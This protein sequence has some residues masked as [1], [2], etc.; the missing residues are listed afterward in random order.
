MK[1]QVN[2]QEEITG[3]LKKLLLFLLGSLGIFYLFFG[4]YLHSKYKNL[5]DLNVCKWK[6]FYEGNVNSDILILGSSK[7]LRGYNP[8]IISE[9]LK[10]TCF[11]AAEMG[12]SLSNYPRFLHDYLL[13]NNPP[14]LLIINLDIFGFN[15]RDRISRPYDMLPFIP[16]NSRVL[17]EIYQ[18]RHIKYAKTYGYFFYKDE[19]FKRIEFPLK[20]NKNTNGFAPNNK[21]WNNPSKVDTNIKA[22]IFFKIDTI[23]AQSYFNQLNILA[24]KHNIKKVYFVLSPVFYNYLHS[25]KD[26]QDIVDFT[27]KQT[28]SKNR[29][30]INLLHDP[31]SQNTDYFYDPI[32]LNTRGAN[33]FTKKIVNYL[34]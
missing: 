4:V 25:S 24:K 5:N 14:E 9:H 18:F 22:T 27:K 29:Q 26:W 31:I 10:K 8:K 23:K 19:I 12:M 33:I 34:K 21:K 6:K 17:N 30:L 28:T 13:K 32:H 3:I 2:I 7:A 15:F 1:D 16:S 11:N 20:N